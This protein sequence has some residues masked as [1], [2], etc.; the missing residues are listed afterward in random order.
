MPTGPVWS[1]GTSTFM[2][3]AVWQGEGMESMGRLSRCYG[4]ATARRQCLSAAEALCRTRKGCPGTKNEPQ[5]RQGR[6][7]WPAQRRGQMIHKRAYCYGSALRNAEGDA[8][9]NRRMKSLGVRVRTMSLGVAV[10]GLLTYAIES[11]QVSCSA[12]GGQLNKLL[13]QT[14]GRSPRFQAQP[15]SS[16]FD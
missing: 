7:A 1:A 10:R 15:S 5:S 6:K 14:L 9:A 2:V 3:L 16:P 12:G 11:F 13:P 4:L 8:R